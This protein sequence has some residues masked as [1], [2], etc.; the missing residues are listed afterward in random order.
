MKPKKQKTKKEKVETEVSEMYQDFVSSDDPN[1]P[2][3]EMELI[4]IDPILFRSTERG[5]IYVLENAHCSVRPTKLR[6]LNNGGL[7]NLNSMS[8]W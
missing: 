8:R 5:V 7:M 4:H 2:T 1:L 6:P 3:G